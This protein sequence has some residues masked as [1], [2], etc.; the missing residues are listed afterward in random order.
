MYRFKLITLLAGCLLGVSCSRT[1][2]PKSSIVALSVD[3]TIVTL[4]ENRAGVLERV[5]RVDPDVGSVATTRVALSTDGLRVAMG[6]EDGGILVYEILTGAE[7]LS[8]NAAPSASRWGGTAHEEWADDNETQIRGLEFVGNDTKLVVA[9][10]DGLIREYDL[11]SQQLVRTLQLDFPAAAVV[12]N[13]NEDR[14]LVG[15]DDGHVCS[16]DSVT[17]VLVQTYRVADASAPVALVRY[18]NDGAYVLASLE[19]YDSESEIENGGT[20]VDTGL[21]AWDAVSG[22]RVIRFEMRA[23]G[24]ARDSGGSWYVGRCAATGANFNSLG[25]STATGVERGAD[26]F[27][28]S[29][30]P[31]TETLLV[32][33]RGRFVEIREASTNGVRVTCRLD[34]ITPSSL[35]FDAPSGQIA[36]GHH[37]GGLTVLRYSPSPTPSIRTVSHNTVFGSAFGITVASSRLLL[38]HSAPITGL[39]SSKNAKYVAS[40]DSEGS[41]VLWTFG[42]GGPPTGVLLPLTAANGVHTQMLGFDPAETVLRAVRSDGGMEVFPLP[43]PGPSTTVAITHPVQGTLRALAILDLGNGSLVVGTDDNGVHVVN[44]TT[45]VVSASPIA[46]NPS[47]ESSAFLSFTV[48]PIGAVVAAPRF[49]RTKDLTVS[50][51]TA[52]AAGTLT[53][54]ATFRGVRFRGAQVASTSTGAFVLLAEQYERRG[55]LLLN[56]ADLTLLDSQKGV[57]IRAGVGPVQ[58]SKYLGASKASL[59]VIDVSSGDL[60][61]EEFPHGMSDS[62]AI[63]TSETSG[64]AFLGLRS[65]AIVQVGVQ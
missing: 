8:V 11:S 43:G 28:G 46:S 17:G 14:F 24:A 26:V 22:A 13:S 65:G 31:S 39:V 21:T 44:S 33:N 57:S 48:L 40:I 64:Q 29:V 20:L 6:D 45:G 47:L 60:D 19:E 30:A 37:A 7:V 12:V 56:S 15:T 10:G 50:P 34:P 4:E 59:A 41:V 18:A 54:T 1:A 32:S 2:S 55:V 23:D 25:V 5:L 27:L 9:V 63:A 58:P 3:T 51:L 49:L 53:P 52:L 61:I 42:A 36:V 38:G 16:L 62:T 35:A